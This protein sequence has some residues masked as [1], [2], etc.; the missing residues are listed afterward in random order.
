MAA[1]SELEV[2]LDLEIGNL[3]AAGYALELRHP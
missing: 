3:D 2:R 1:Q